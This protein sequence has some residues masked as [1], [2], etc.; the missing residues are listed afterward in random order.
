LTQDQHTEVVDTTDEGQES[1]VITDL[2]A[3][4][5]EKDKQLKAKPDRDEL[6]V[7]LKAELANDSAIEALLVG[8]GHPTGILDTIKRKLGDTET[9]KETVGKALQDIGYKVEITDVSSEQDSQESTVNTELATVTGL[10]AQVQ[11]A[12]QGS[13][14]V[15]VK[16]QI[17]ETET[18]DQLNAIM[19]K[20]GLLVEG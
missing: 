6:A 20:A 2:R 7:E 4:L 14:T 10:S 16:T 11:S 18:E 5:R 13:A 3:Q 9:T 19:E 15:D 12:V 1:S 8:F 17:G